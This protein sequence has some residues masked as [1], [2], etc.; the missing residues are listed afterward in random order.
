MKQQRILALG[1]FDGVHLGHGA[2]L[3]ACRALAEEKGVEAG[4]VTFT[5]HPDALVSGKDP[6][7]IN[8]P[9]DRQRLM[10]EL[11]RMDTVIALP[12]D[13]AMMAMPWQDFFR[14]LREQYG[15]V[16]LVC[17]HDF[18]FGRRGAGNPEVLR[19][20]CAEAGMDCVVVPE[21]KIDGVTISST[22]IRQL[23]EL[24][25][26]ET[27]K[28][29]LGHPHF[30]T[31]QVTQGRK[32][33][34]KLGFPT[35]NVPIPAGI[36]CPRRGVYACKVRVDGRA[37]TAVT[38]VGSRPTVEGHQVR[39]ESWILDFEGDLYGREIRLEFHYFLRP[40]KKF[41]SLERLKAAVLADGARARN[42]FA[43][44]EN[45]DRG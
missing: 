23:L 30:L 7:L 26:M 12:F 19:R 13:K 27:A 33:G 31:G 2:L 5:T 21:Q 17:G 14:L 39:A 34:H 18:R 20:A 16:G 45:P 24:G 25:H 3:R 6:G 36:V 11:Y 4:A 22:Y 28:R 1:F 10:E 9:A 15:A 42:Y 32:L 37:Y 44:R 29:F 41:E 38:N 40:E 8:T 43:E 35:A